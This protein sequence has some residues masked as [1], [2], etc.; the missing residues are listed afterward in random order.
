MGW[1]RKTRSEMSTEEK[2]EWRIVYQANWQ[3]EVVWA[4]YKMTKLQHACSCRQIIEWTFP[5][6]AKDRRQGG[7]MTLRTNTWKLWDWKGRWQVT[8]DDV[9]ETSMTITTT[10]HDW[11]SL[12][13]RRSLKT[14]NG[15]E[16]EVNTLSIIQR[17][18]S[19]KRPEFSLAGSTLLVNFTLN[20]HTPDHGSTL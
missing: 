5:E 7:W 9:E 10:L 19:W 6:E 3:I 18:H 14:L 20:A 17:K 1:H 8:G 4:C 13:K 12:K 15:S 11:T 16:E 2:S